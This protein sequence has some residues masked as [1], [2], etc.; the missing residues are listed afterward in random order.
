MSM[1]VNR[2]V[3][4]EGKNQIRFKW[5]NLCPFIPTIEFVGHWKS[6]KRLMG[7][8]CRVDSCLCYVEEKIERLIS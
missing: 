7:T 6:Y 3:D 4:E 8:L 1:M 5:N 2:L